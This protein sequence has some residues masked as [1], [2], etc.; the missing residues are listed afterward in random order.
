MDIDCS[1]QTGHRI[2]INNKFIN[3]RD[4]L[5][6]KCEDHVSAV[7]LKDGK[8]EYIT[9][10]LTVFENKLRDYGFIRIHR[11]TL[12]NEFYVIKIDKKKQFI[13]IAE[14]IMLKVARRML[15]LFK[16]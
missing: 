13:Y 6:I 1:K 5:Y 9:Q 2:M 7:Y 16:N 11:N 4:I 3:I 12:I 10:T 8:T 15:K 14:K